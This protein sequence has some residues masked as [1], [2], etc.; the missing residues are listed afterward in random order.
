MRMSIEYQ[1]NNGGGRGTGHGAVAIVVLIAIAGYLLYL[2]PGAIKEF[3]NV[4]SLLG[5]SL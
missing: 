4:I 1:R 5:L 3:G 2:Y